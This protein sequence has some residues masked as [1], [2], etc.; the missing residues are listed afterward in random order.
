[1]KVTTLHLPTGKSCD[2]VRVTALGAGGQS[3][4]RITRSVGTG[5]KG[6]GAYRVLQQDPRLYEPLV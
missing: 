4:P 3:T 1:M 2:W 5:E 6:V